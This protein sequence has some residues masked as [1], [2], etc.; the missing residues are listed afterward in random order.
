MVIVK[1]TKNAESG[2]MPSTEELQ[3]MGEYNEQLV[4]AGIMVTG[5]GLKPSAAGARVRFKGDALTVE[6]G[7]FTP[8]GEQVAGFWIWEVA[9]MDEAIAW[10][11]RCPSPMPGEEGVLELRPFVEAADFGDAYTD[12]VRE[13]EDRLR[14]EL[15]SQK[16]GA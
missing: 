16:R 4:K 5:E 14:V 9:S 7:P 3:A 8:V 2:R 13:Q 11:R 10:A 12:E 15:E 6:H 1:S